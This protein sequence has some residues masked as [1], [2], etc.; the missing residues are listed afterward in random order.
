[1]FV[2]HGTDHI[3]S[4]PHNKERFYMITSNLQVDLTK[5]TIKFSH[6]TLTPSIN[7][8]TPYLRCSLRLTFGR[9]ASD[10]WLSRNPSILQNEV[11][12]KNNRFILTR[13]AFSYLN[14]TLLKI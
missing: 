3:I 7:I 10:P 2:I 1:M 12:I 11:Y 6:Q 5:Q 9:A 13:N 14:K 4:K 8:F